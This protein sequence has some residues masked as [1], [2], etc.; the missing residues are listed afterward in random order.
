[1]SGRS[2]NG[3]TDLFPFRKVNGVAAPRTNFE[4]GLELPG[5]YPDAHRTAH[6]D[7]QRVSALPAPQPVGALLAD[8]RRRRRSTAIRGRSPF[9]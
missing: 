7:R 5:E 9:S 2:M 1:M 6:D 3:S 8:P 4:V